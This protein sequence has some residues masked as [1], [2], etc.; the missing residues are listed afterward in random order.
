MHLL[1]LLFQYN[2]QWFFPTTKI[3]LI[4]LLRDKLS[5]F[6]FNSS[7]NIYEVCPEKVQTMLI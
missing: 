2:I 1:F 5:D 3:S 7:N 4:I 6:I